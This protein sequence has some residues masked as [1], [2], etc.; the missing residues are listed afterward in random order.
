MII[1]FPCPQC[2]CPARLEIPDQAAESAGP[3]GK[4]PACQQAFEVQ[5]DYRAD[6][7]ICPM[8]GNHELYRKKNFP[9][10]LGVSILAGASLG[11][12]AGMAWH[13]PWVAW[14]ILIGSAIFDGLLYFWVGDVVVCYKCNA[15]CTGIP[16]GPNHKPHELIIAERYRQ[17][18][19]RREQLGLK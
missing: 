14:S 4:C 11:F 8:C 5:K 18:R 13:Y 16:P 7:T 19:L 2:Q 10:W 6:L 9:H 12:L 3:A 1:R 15:H 17:E